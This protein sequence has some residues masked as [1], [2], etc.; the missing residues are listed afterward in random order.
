[1]STPT[2]TV[3]RL[4]A[5]HREMLPIQHA[6]AECRTPW[7]CDVSRLLDVVVAAQAFHDNV[8]DE[9]RLYDALD[10]LEDK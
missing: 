2:D 4:R 10:A 1:M 7:P 5:L 3:S 6:C 9:A 8:T